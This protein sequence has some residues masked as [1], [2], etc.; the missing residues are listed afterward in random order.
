MEH[1]RSMPFF[2]VALLILMTNAAYAELEVMPT[3]TPAAT[4]VPLAPPLHPGSPVTPPQLKDSQVKTGDVK[5]VTVTRVVGEVGPRVVTSREVRMNEAISQ[6]LQVG[7]MPVGSKIESK[8]KILNLDDPAFPAQVL[9]V[10]DEWTVYLEAVEI[11][12]KTAEKAEVARL[13]KVV[14]DHW[15]GVGDWERLEASNTEIHDIIERKLAAQ[16]LEKL[17]GDASLVNVSDAE[18]LQYFKKNRL[19]FGNLP[20]EN[21]KDNIK[22]A[23]VR[24]QTERRLAEWRTVLRRKYRVRNFVGA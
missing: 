10:L 9:K 8:K 18:A 20:F 16:S 19:R 21:F 23:L 12:S 15:K 3:P 1:N 2:F 22:S 7:E 14:I 5:T 24:S 13:T 11:G 4:P 17:K 6:V